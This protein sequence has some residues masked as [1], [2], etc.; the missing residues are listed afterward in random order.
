MELCQEEM[1]F[2]GN[3]TSANANADADAYARRILSEKSRKAT[4]Q[5]STSRFVLAFIKSS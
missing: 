4:G 5:N 1:R 3:A 2:G